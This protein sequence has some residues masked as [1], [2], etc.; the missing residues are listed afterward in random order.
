MAKKRKTT[1]KPTKTALEFN[2]LKKRIR[3]Q[4]R[5][6]NKKG[7]EMV[8]VADT[9]AG[10]KPTRSSL[11]ELKR[12][13][14]QWGAMIKDLKAEARKIQKQKGVSAGV[15]YRYLSARERDQ[16]GTG[17]LDFEDVVI[18]SF[19][20]QV[21]KMPNY[22][23]REKMGEFV[24]KLCQAVGDAEAARILAETAENEQDFEA[25]LQYE[26]DD[27]A[28]YNTYQLIDTIAGKLEDMEMPL[29]ADEIR[30]FMDTIE[31]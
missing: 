13:A 6:Y 22:S 7:F 11:A 4:E 1:K 30:D 5:Y 2:K 18:K 28:M 14:K 9:F 16:A 20:D 15:A 25:L 12:Y 3:E 8:S 26:T 10:V 21:N 23:S 29:A 31:Y 19:I 24:N 17:I 27:V